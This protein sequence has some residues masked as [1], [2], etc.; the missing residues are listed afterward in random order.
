MAILNNES[1]CLLLHPVSD[2]CFYTFKLGECSLNISSMYWYYPTN[3]GKSR[4]VKK[5]SECS[6]IST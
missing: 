4:H 5:D 1:K 6:G 3:L 2:G